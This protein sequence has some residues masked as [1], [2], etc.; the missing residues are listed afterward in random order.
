MAQ[1]EKPSGS[2]SWSVAESAPCLLDQHQGELPQQQCRA[3]HCEHTF[4]NR[5]H[6]R[7]RLIKRM[8][9]GLA[10]KHREDNMST[11]STIVNGSH[12]AMH[13]PAVAVAEEPRLF[14]TA[15]GS[16]KLYHDPSNK[17]SI[18]SGDTIDYVIDMVASREPKA[19]VVLY[20]GPSTDGAI[21][22]SATWAL[23]SKHM[24]ICW[25]KPNTGSWHDALGNWN[26]QAL[27]LQAPGGGRKLKCEKT[28]VEKKD[29]QIFDVNTKELLAELIWAELDEKDAHAAVFA[30]K[31]PLTK[32]E[33][34]T[35][36]ILTL[37]SIKKSEANDAA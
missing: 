12:H 5:S 33:E 37:A 11:A 16:L 32:H 10:E 28:S 25:G 13:T 30:W 2:S 31:Q 3:E 9:G 26:Y 29:R 14:R 19:K 27:S 7:I 8:M 34:V 24:Q 21:L 4:C 1:A 18:S 23:S 36:L 35:A 20:E 17:Y 6:T 22:A 15:Q